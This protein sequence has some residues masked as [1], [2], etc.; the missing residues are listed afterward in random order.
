MQRH[1][2]GISLSFRDESQRGVRPHEAPR[3]LDNRTTEWNITGTDAPDDGTVPE[4][5]ENLAVS[6]AKRQHRD[7]EAFPADVVGRAVVTVGSDQTLR[8]WPLEVSALQHLV[9]SSAGRNL[10]PDEVPVGATL[11][12]EPLCP[13]RR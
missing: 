8:V 10:R 3:G 1:G 2:R 4:F 6:I 7:Q 11:P 5:T 9:C 13:S 12:A